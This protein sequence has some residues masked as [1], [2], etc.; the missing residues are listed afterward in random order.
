MTMENEGENLV[1][2]T[3]IHSSITTITSDFKLTN[4]KCSEDESVD[5]K[6]DIP[7]IKVEIKKKPSLA[8]NYDLTDIKFD[9]NYTRT[10]S[11]IP[12]AQERADS[13]FNTYSLYNFEKDHVID[14]GK[15]DSRIKVNESTAPPNA[16]NNPAASSKQ[17]V[18]YRKFRRF[19][20]K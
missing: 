3:N 11:R 4:N 10:Q 12:S 2:S 16:N 20:L 7:Q 1:I 8:K 19:F 5:M 6:Y 13:A 17:N 18:I 9:E 14:D 15:G